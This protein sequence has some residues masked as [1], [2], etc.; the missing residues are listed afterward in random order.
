MTKIDNELKAE[1]E[2]IALEEFDQPKKDHE[3]STHYKERKHTFLNAMASSKNKKRRWTPQRILLAAAIALFAIPSSVYAATKLYQWYVTKE[4]YQV[5][6]SLN[7]DQTG[8]NQ[9]YYQL[10]LGY[11]PTEMTGN[12]ESNKYSYQNNRDQGGLS[13]LLWKIN[14]KADFDALFTDNYQETTY[15]GH[16][17]LVVKK[18][19]TIDNEE[20]DFNRITYLLFEKEGYVL[21]TYIG[22][23]VP[24]DELDKILSQVTLKETE[25]D[26]A[27]RTMN[28]DD[29]KKRLTE[30]KEPE[31]QEQD[32]LAS[33]SSTIHQVGETVTVNLWEN[34]KIKFTIDQVEFF[35]TIQDFDKNNFNDYPLESFTKEK[36]INQD[37]HLVPFK[38]K[39]L[40]LGDGK[41]NIDQVLNEKLVQPRFVY[42][43][44]TIENT[45][46]TPLKEIYIQDS[47]KLLKKEGKHFIDAT[48]DTNKSAFSGQVD[49]LD[50]HGEGKK[51]FRLPTLAAKEK[52][53]IHYGFFIDD[54]QA[55][56]MFLPLFNYGNEDLD[57][58]KLTLIDIRP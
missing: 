26:Q 41:T 1:A 43:T 48:I 31:L 21:Q 15:N 5:S 7:R 9:K 44:A 39:K 25:K 54:Y 58:N 2:K 56:Q 32:K 10:K 47:P 13:F 24:N 12:S 17:A 27:T 28:F 6:L 42:L 18:T 36:I 34:E 4:G 19:K 38:Q 11:L 53:V 40:K 35:D 23:D 37:N 51:F 3:F 16:K 14:K 45:E 57:S 22:K 30:E 49:Y 46:N 29:Y 50:N 52:R 8:T 33:N 55:N 20:Q